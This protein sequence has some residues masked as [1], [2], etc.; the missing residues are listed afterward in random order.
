MAYLSD[1]RAAVRT[2]LEGIEGM[3]VYE[4]M[5]DS[6]NIPCAFIQ[7][8]SP[9]VNYRTRFGSGKAEW[10]FFLTVLVSRTQEEA[11]QFELD[12]YL[13]P[14]GP[15]VTALHGGGSLGGV[16]DYATVVRADRYG[17][18][19]V[20]DTNYFGVQLMVEVTA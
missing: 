4:W 15:I 11:A 6:V 8:G 17:S 12:Q 3:T 9:L 2:A 20:G 18:F 16:V 10:T 1:I 13:S 5:P 14:D 7:P 19:R